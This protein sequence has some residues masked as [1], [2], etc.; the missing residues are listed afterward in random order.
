VRPGFVDFHI[1]STYSSDGE[2]TPAQIVEMARETGFVAVSFADHD[3]VAAYPDA[4][5]TGRAAGVEVVPN[6]E[7][8]AI[9]EGREFHCLLPL[10]DWTHPAVARIAAYVSDGRWIEAR[11]RV[12]NLRRLGFDLTWEEVAAAVG[13]TPPLGVKIAQIL[14]DKAESRLD[15]RLRSYYDESGRPR[16]P[17]FFY[18]DYFMENKPAF[19]PKRHIPLLDVLDLAPASGAVPV[20]SHPGAYFQNTTRADLAVLRSRGLEGLEVYTSYHNESQTRFY[21]DAARD[22][23][24]VATAG[25]DFHGRVKPQVP[26]GLIRDGHYEMIDALILRRRADYA[27]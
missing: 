1:H 24:L 22:F 27:V 3:T 8:T 17:K 14:L 15:P 20:L 4:I 5:E 21:A 2:F 7:V 23:G 9:Y 13:A 10:L 6:M 12:E 25:S 16:A 18:I 26:F 11:E 19:A